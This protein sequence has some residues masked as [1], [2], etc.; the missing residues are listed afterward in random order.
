MITQTELLAIAKGP[1]CLQPKII[2]KHN[3][4]QL[5]K[6]KCE[7]QYG[8]IRVSHITTVYPIFFLA[9]QNHISTQKRALYVFLFCFT[10]FT[11][12]VFFFIDGEA[13]KNHFIL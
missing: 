10:I 11:L 8:E 2:Q 3:F 6:V 1:S 4:W 13:H 12:Q 9:Q 7:S 5:P